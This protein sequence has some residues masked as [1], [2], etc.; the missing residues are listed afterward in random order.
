MVAET[1]AIDTPAA[2]ATSCRV[3]MLKHL[4]DFSLLAET[5]S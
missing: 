4:S 2:L 3:G 5:F 1:V